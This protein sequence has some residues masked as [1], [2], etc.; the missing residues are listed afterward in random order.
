MLIGILEAALVIGV[1][2]L[3]LYGA[4]RLLARPAD[5]QLPASQAGQW[6]TAHYDVD[7]VTNVVVQKLS[8]TGVNVLDEHVVAKLTIDDP[9]YDAKFLAAMAAARQRRALFESETE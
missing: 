3:L 8:P 4:V 2:G 7:G 6:V 1:A 5:R 9:D